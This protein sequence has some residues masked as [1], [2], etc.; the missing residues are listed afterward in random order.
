M[1]IPQRKLT[2][3]V[4]ALISVGVVVL[5]P[6]TSASSGDE[7]LNEQLSA[8]L[9]Q[10]AFTGRVGSTLEQRLGRDRKSVV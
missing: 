6:N 5:T 9:S 7:F 10:H 3:I 1:S 4:L 8:A 2:I